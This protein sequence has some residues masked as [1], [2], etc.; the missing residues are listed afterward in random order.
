MPELFAWSYKRR[1]K[2]GYLWQDLLDDDLITPI[3]DNEY[4]LKGCEISTANFGNFSENQETS[5]D[6]SAKTSSEL[7]EDSALFSSESSTLTDD[8][9]KPEEGKDS[10]K[11]KQ[12]LETR[13]EKFDNLPSSYPHKNDEKN[14][15]KNTSGMFRNLI[16]C[17]AA[18]TKESAVV[19]IKRKKLMPCR[20]SHDGGKSTGY[21]KPISPAYRPVNGPN[22]SQCGK[23]FK[24]EKMHKHMMS[25]KG[26]KDLTPKP[27]SHPEAASAETASEP[28]ESMHSSSYQQSVST[29]FLTR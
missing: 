12:E 14:K 20:K 4:V 24:P 13:S 11:T 6:E 23:Q 18:D 21:Q 29:Y 15:S 2:T 19:V 17:G 10:E 26:M 7:D 3:S 8:S 28:R 5:L 1:Y 25:C 27:T 9:P 22:C 16:T